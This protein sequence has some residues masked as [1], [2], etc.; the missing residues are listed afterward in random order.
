MAI[1]LLT[2]ND[3]YDCREASYI[4]DIEDEKN[5]IPVADQ[6]F[7]TKVYVIETKKRYRMNSNNEW[8]E[9]TTSS[10]GGSSLPP[11]SAADNGDVL[12]VVGGAWTKAA[13]PTPFVEATLTASLNSLF[14]VT[15]WTINKT[16]V[17]LSE[18]I[19]GGT[20]VKVNVT[21]QPIYGDAQD[22]GYVFAEYAWNKD[23]N[24][25][26]VKM[27]VSGVD[28]SGTYEVY[29][30]SDDTITSKLISSPDKYKLVS[31]PLTYDYQFQ[32]YYSTSHVSVIIDAVETGAVVQVT[33]GGQVYHL[34]YYYHQQNTDVYY[35]KFACINGSDIQVLS[36]GRNNTP[37]GQIW[38]SL[39]TVS[40]DGPIEL[41]ESNGALVANLPS[42]KEAYDFKA[43]VGFY[44]NYWDSSESKQ[45]QKTFS[46]VSY[47]AWGLSTVEVVIKDNSND[48]L[49]KSTGGY[50]DRTLSFQPYTPTT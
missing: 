5:Q 45:I 1:K 40:I 11:V 15:G 8:I 30:N 17:E 19:I 16:Y 28:N 24:L 20:P 47:E 44:R 3:R 49:Y 48:S 22:T 26:A 27:M 38:M 2:V 6:V 18:A 9:D 14:L 35:F 42:G 23:A 46:L 7:G 32:E 43:Y 12:M 29:L 39:N 50:Y 21:K 34:I 10:S 13:A 41:S 36:N 25:W 33:Y 37:T 4:V 31:I